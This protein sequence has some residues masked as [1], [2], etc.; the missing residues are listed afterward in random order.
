MN[1]LYEKSEDQ[2]VIA[3]YVYAKTSDPYAYSDAA[4]TVK[5]DAVELKEVFEKG[6]VVVDGTTLYSP[7]SFKVAN[8]VG[9]ITYV[10]TDGT[11]AT[12]AVLATLAS[13]EYVVG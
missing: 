12:T 7:V 13:K 2:H 1:R 8:G 11:T 6:I 10:K 3:T 4:K 5:I 9:T